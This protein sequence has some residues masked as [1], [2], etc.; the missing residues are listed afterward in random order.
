MR[1]RVAFRV[2]TNGAGR[3]VC[4]LAR[5]H[6]VER[7]THRS[8]RSCRRHGRR[9][10]EGRRHGRVVHGR[11]GESSGSS[12]CYPTRG[13]P[14]SDRRQARPLDTGT[15]R[16]SMGTDD[17]SV[18]FTVGLM[19][20]DRQRGGGRRRAGCEETL[21]TVLPTR[22]LTQAASEPAGEVGRHAA[23]G[24]SSVA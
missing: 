21:G 10:W 3:L 7:G 6:L 11:P 4:A 24:A 19:R 8:E 1:C 12:T 22:C 20:I 9:S 18:G 13:E 16:P 14:S 5:R 17:C 23:I 2:G 15:M